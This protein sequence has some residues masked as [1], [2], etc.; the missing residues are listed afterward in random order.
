MRPTALLATS[1]VL[2]AGCAALQA[3]SGSP[4][5]QG[6]LWGP[7][8]RL[9]APSTPAREAYLQETECLRLHSRVVGG[10]ALPDDQ[11]VRACLLGKGWRD[12]SA[13]TARV[14]RTAV[15]DTVE[16]AAP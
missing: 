4:F 7:L 10:T 9:W 11:A 1:A 13:D 3:P 8:T 15:A 16:R 6:H 14:W 2:L 5:R 12:T